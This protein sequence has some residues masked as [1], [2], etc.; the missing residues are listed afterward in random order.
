[1]FLLFL[2]FALLTQQ[3]A[4]AFGPFIAMAVGWALAMVAQ[5]WLKMTI[6]LIYKRKRAE[7]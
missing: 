3:L 1:M 4:V 2:A 6:I 5:A 7:S